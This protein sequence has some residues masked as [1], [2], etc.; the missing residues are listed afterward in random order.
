LFVLLAFLFPVA[1]Y[2]LILAVLNSRRYPTL[3]SGPWDFAGVLFAT[4]GFLLVG[5]PT[6]LAGLNSQWRYALQHGR[7]REVRGQPS[8][9]WYFWILVWGIYFV[10]VLG[11]AVFVAWRRRPVTVI[12]HIDPPG[13][14]EALGRALDQLGL[15]GVRVANRVIIGAAGAVGDANAPNLEVMP[16]APRSVGVY[17]A[18]VDGNVELLGRTPPP[19]PTPQH[20]GPQRTAVVEL[21]PLPSIQHMTLHWDIGDPTL[22]RD[23]EAELA[24]TL[25]EVETYPNPAAN[26]FLTVASIVFAFILFG[27][28]LLIL[29]ESGRK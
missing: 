13:F 9:W 24:K 27:L 28:L 19:H 14:E 6:I 22:R 12:Y 5:G 18:T 16:S 10:I 11:G 23:I 26:W 17:P 29:V 7:F 21:E 3:V 25:A 15:E 2:C 1:I 20:I 8:E 4:S